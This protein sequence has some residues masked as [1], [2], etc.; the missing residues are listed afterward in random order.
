MIFLI[1]P[2]LTSEKNQKYQENQ[3]NGD[4]WLSF[5]IFKIS[6]SDPIF[7]LNDENPSRLAT[8]QF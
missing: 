6:N 2:D 8:D 5:L 4:L 3:E 7:G 1:F